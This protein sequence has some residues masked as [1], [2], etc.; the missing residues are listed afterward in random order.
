MYHSFLY[1]KS[2][3]FFQNDLFQNVRGRF[4]VAVDDHL[5]AG[6]LFHVLGENLYSYLASGDKGRQA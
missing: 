6:E 4:G 5:A 3:T 1:V 2:L